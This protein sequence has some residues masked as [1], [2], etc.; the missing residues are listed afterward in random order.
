MIRTLALMIVA[1]LIVGCEDSYIHEC[2]RACELG[3]HAMVSWSKANGCQCSVDAPAT[4][5]G[6][7]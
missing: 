2:A 4:V 3:H 7:P 6:A 1:A 5:K